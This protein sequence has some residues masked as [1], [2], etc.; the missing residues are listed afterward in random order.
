VLEILR[1]ISVKIPE[2][3]F[4][5]ATSGNIFGNLQCKHPA[6]EIVTFAQ[7]ALAILWLEITRVKFSILL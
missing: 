7:F 3:P 1:L 6:I 5:L 2:G 4:I